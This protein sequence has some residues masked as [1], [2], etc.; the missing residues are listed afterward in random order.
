[1]S[2]EQ[3][4]EVFTD[5]RLSDGRTATIMEAKGNHLNEAMYYANEKSMEAHKPFANQTDIQE[6]LLELLVRIDGYAVT[7]QEMGNLSFSDTARIHEIV[8][9]M[10]QPNYNPDVIKATEDTVAVLRGLVKPELPIH[11]IKSIQAAVQPV[12]ENFVNGLKQYEVH[13]IM[14]MFPEDREIFSDLVKLKV[15]WIEL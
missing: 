13:E 8:N 10:M 6:K 14:Q 5:M 7:R 2:L 15:N 12:G 3:E 4:D 1:M 11:W 9:S